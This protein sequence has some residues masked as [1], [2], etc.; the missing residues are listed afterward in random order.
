L[1]LW[2]IGCIKKSGQELLM[3]TLRGGNVKGALNLTIPGIVVFS[4]IFVTLKSLIYVSSFITFPA[5]L[6][7][8]SIGASYL[9][10]VLYTS[11]N[12][13]LWFLEYMVPMFY[14]H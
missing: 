10:G 1:F 9:G 2:F 11:L 4:I 14:I 12:S 13:I 7:D 5:F 8:A 3:L 6:S